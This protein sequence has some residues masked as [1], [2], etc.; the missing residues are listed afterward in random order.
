MRRHFWIVPAVAIVIVAGQAPV[1]AT[2]RWAPASSASIHPGVQTI[3][4]GAQC[5][6]NFI[7][8]DSKY[9]YIGQA[10]HCTSKGGT[11][12]TDG[13]KTATY[14]LGTAVQIK[15]A[16]RPG[17]MVYNSWITMKAVH[18]SNGNIC[19]GNDFSLVRIDPA[20]TGRVNPSIPFWGG[21]TGL[22]GSIS[23]GKDVYTF[24]NSELRAGVTQLSPKY[25]KAVQ[26]ENGG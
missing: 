2:P 13:C 16:T 25:G 20:D 5:T 23:T 6:A 8:Y 11:T 18:E 26:D 9:E 12:D 3:S 14:P 1:S 19:A 10:S 21:P 17:I 4:Q 24:G 15:G 22:S 7:F